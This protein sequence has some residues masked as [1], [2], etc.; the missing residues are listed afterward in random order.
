MFPVYATSRQTPVSVYPFTLSSFVL[1]Y[2]FGIVLVGEHPSASASIGAVLILVG[3]YS[4]SQANAT[5]GS[6]LPDQ[7]T[8]QSP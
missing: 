6:V 3:L 7:N 5:V 1:V 8:N 2:L 4:I